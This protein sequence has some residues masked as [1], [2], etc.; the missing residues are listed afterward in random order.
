MTGRVELEYPTPKIDKLRAFMAAGA[1]R[2]ALSMAARF[3]RLGAHADAIRAGH[4]AMQRPDFQRQLKRDP[5]VVVAA[6]IAAL[7]ARYGNE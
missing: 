7:K 1:W 4:E 3:P 5:D 6:G 2:A